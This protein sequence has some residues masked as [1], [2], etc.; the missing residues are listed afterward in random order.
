MTLTQNG[1][2]VTG[3]YAHQGGTVIGTV[4]G[5]V[6]SGTWAQPGNNRSGPFEFT[7][8]DNGMEFTIKWKYQGNANWDSIS[9]RGTRK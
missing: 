4:S 2:S 5:N 7:M 8:S 6:L 3:T 1:N 9:D